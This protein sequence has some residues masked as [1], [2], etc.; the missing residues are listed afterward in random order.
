MKLL[1]LKMLEVNK[2]IQALKK[3][4]KRSVS[5]GQTDYRAGASWQRGSGT[6]SDTSISW[7]SSYGGKQ[8]SGCKT[9][10]SIKPT[11]KGPLNR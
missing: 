3:N 10:S 4:S 5:P 2:D 6:S 9:T 7:F 11:G 8:D 1:N